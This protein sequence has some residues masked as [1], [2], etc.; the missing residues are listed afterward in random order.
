MP[1]VR[2]RSS[3]HGQGSRGR[4][5]GR[6]AAG[7]GRGRSGGSHIV[8]RRPQAIIDAGTESEF[9]E[10]YAS[11]DNVDGQGPVEEL[12]LSGLDSA[13]S[14]QLVPLVSPKKDAPLENDA[15][16]KSIVPQRTLKKD[17]LIAA[18]AYT[19]AAAPTATQCL[20]KCGLTNE[21]RSL[22]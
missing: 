6:G 18:G 12:N 4:G 2:G 19:R 17:Q 21:D 10:D 8:T 3:A 16:A 11:G 1:P 22:V 20:A 9:S 7:R 5:G 15:A 14:A 13:G